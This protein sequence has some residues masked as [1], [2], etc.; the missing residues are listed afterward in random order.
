MA[1][2]PRWTALRLS[3][4][5]CLL[6]MTRRSATRLALPQQQG[7]EEEGGPTDAAE[8]L[9][10]LRRLP[11]GKR[12]HEPCRDRTGAREHDVRGWAQQPSERSEHERAG[13]PGEVGC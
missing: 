9:E 6:S 1:A 10:R 5:T 4:D 7:E 11:I 12:G 3:E 8:A 2:T 13:C